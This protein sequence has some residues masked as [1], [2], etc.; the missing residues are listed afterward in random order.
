MAITSPFAKIFDLEIFGSDD[1]KT[2]ECHESFAGPC[3]NESLTDIKY[4][5]T[6]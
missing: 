6:F 4:S 2:F 1:K 3:K 5:L